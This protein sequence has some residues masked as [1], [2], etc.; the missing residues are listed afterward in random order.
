M[1]IRT[2]QPDSESVRLYGSF[3]LNI[4]D[5]KRIHD[6]APEG[7]KLRLA[8]TLKDNTALVAETFEDLDQLP[9]GSNRNLKHFE[10]QSEKLG[11]DGWYDC[12]I[13]YNYRSDPSVRVRINIS[14][15]ETSV[16]NVKER[17]T[18]IIESSRRWYSIIF[19]EF[20]FEAVTA[21]SLLLSLIAAIYYNIAPDNLL[22]TVFISISVLSL[23]ILVSTRSVFFSRI[24]NHFGRGQEQENRKRN[25]RR[26][27][28]ALFLALVA[29]PSAQMSWNMISSG[30]GS[31]EVPI[32][33]RAV[34]E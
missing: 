30:A 13:E 22:F 7:S 9:L 32:E 2:V 5:L 29:V 26:S 3:E 10:I 31:D 12:R 34:D 8:L 18:S 17:I 19:S 4:A 21:F 15:L 25:L 16:S 33:D 1:P 28:A 11:G 27:I 24:V 14:P 20:V 6:L 23:F